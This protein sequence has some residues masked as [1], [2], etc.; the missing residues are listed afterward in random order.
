[1]PTFRISVRNTKEKKGY[2][3]NY[4]YKNKTLSNQ[5]MLFIVAALINNT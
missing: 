4:N 1:M 2:N 3:K 5:E